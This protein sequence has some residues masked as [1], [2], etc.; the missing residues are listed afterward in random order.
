MAS[1]R[2]V[3][4]ARP[5][6]CAE[7]SGCRISSLSAR[8]RGKWWKVG[9]QSLPTHMTM[10]WARSPTSAWPFTGITVP[11][12]TE[13]PRSKQY[14]DSYRDDRKFRRMFQWYMRAVK[15]GDGD[16]AVRFGY[17]Y[18]YGIGTRRDPS[19]ARHMFRRALTSRDI[20]D[21]GREEA[22][23]HLAVSFVPQ[24]KGISGWPFRY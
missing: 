20:S 6:D 7:K 16:A 19:L 15:M 13:I 17:C 12:G 21:L 11:L 18:Q 14:G 4:Q 1:G 22:M 24:W 9:A 3:S 2:Y 23:Y 5:G 10:A 8:R